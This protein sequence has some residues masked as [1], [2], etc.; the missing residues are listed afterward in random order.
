M[1]HEGRHPLV[2]ERYPEARVLEGRPDGVAQTDG[3]CR[4]RHVQG[5]FLFPIGREMLPEEG[6]EVGP[7]GPVQG[8]A[9]TGLVVDIGRD[10]L[11]PPLGERLGLVG[12]DIARHGTHGK[13][14]VRV[15][16]YRACQTAALCAGR[17]E[18]GNDLSIAHG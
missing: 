6:D 7:V 11:R 15:V 9:Q 1:L 16:E 14:T 5:L 10:D 17:A 18:D 2:L 8:P 3:L 12:V 4:G 13:T